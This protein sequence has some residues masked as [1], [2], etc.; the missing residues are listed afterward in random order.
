[1]PLL[2]GALLAAGCATTN[3][4]VVTAAVRGDAAAVA[5]LLGSGADPN[6]GSERRVSAL[7]FAASADANA[8]CE[9]GQTPLMT[10]AFGG[11]F[12]ILQQ[13]LRAG[14]RVDAVDENGNTALSNAADSGQVA[15][16]RA[17]IDAR[18]SVNHRSARGETAL[19][20]AVNRRHPEVADV[21]RGAGGTE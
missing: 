8:I 14:A 19:K 5:P 18:A 21:L 16:V 13:L 9:A 4:P 6:V 7:G 17:L 3:P 1:M 10:A 11:Y 2:A 12:P 20:V 15:A